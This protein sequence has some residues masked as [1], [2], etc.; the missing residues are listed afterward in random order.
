MAYVRKTR[1]EYSI[2]G[3]YCGEWST[4]CYC[5]DRKDAREQLRC[6]RENCPDTAF[7]IAKHRVPIEEA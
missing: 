5:E 6:Y 3:L 4:E 2:E 1:D 7:R